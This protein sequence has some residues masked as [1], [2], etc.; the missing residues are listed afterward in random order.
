MAMPTKRKT[1]A[2]RKKS[3][4]TLGMMFPLMG[5]DPNFHLEAFAA[6]G[7]NTPAAML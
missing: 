1:I 3:S 5:G 4:E 2:V 6:H 7:Q